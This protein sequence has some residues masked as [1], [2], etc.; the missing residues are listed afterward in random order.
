MPRA[1]APK[2]NATE[3]EGSDAKPPLPAGWTWVTLRDI[4]Q[5]SG[6]ITKGQKRRYGDKVRMVPYLRVANVQRGYFDLS[7]VKE[8]EATDEEIAALRLQPGDIL[9]NE[10]GD[11][12]KLGRGWVWNGELPECVHQNH[13]FR[14]R[15]LDPGISPKFISFYANSEGQRYFMEHATQTTNLASIN[16]TKLGALPIPLPP[17]IE[18]LRIVAELE[19]QFTRLDTGVATL[20]RMKKNLKRYR[21]AVLKAACEGRLVPIEADLARA[22]RRIFES[23]QD[24]LS[25]ILTERR[26]NPQGRG[27]YEE[28]IPSESVNLPPLPAGWQWATVEQLAAPEPY[29]ITDGPFGSNL[30]TEHYRMDGPRVI[31]L[32]NIGDGVY[33]DEEAHIAQEHYER[34]QKH[35]VF[36]NDVVIAAFGENPPRSCVIP[37]SLGPAI[38]KA[39]CI[40]FKPHCDILPKYVN[41]ALNS[42]PVRKRTKGLVHGV[43]RP[44]LNLGEIRL[45][46]LP[47]PPLAEQIRIVAEVD[48]LLSVA[49]EIETLIEVSLHRSI[50]LQ[51][52]L[53]KQ[54][55]GGALASSAERDEPVESLLRRILQTRSLDTKPITK[56]IKKP[57][58]SSYTMKAPPDFQSALADVMAGGPDEPSAWALFKAGRFDRDQVLSF[59]DSIS[60]SV[61][62]I[63]FFANPASQP[64]Q[65]RRRTPKTKPAKGPFRLH[66]LWVKQFKNLEEY[67]VS[68]EPEHALDVLLGWNGTG[69]S[70]LFEVLIAIFRDLYFW[71]SRNRWK[72]QEGLTGFRI[73]YE[74][75]GA[76]FDV[77]WDESAPRPEVQKATD[78]TREASSSAHFL[79]CK[80]E[81]LLLPSFVFWILF[82]PQ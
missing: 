5:I 31:R 47:I 29:S 49:A 21:A 17:A 18:Q 41:A 75:N 39:D 4:A 30:K 62:A 74:I 25:R 51:A 13:V 14:A 20:R 37:E 67:K 46:L 57:N 69:K 59:Y 66:M 32:Q 33:V 6:G 42:E 68:F 65:K 3:P 16:L 71:Q 8:I 63:K 34:L 55:F 73:R 72:P 78:Y 2:L 70:N 11:R 19:K 40:R 56:R 9:F 36:A 82:W 23:G 61:E 50:S 58:E 7:E 1:K 81:E 79:K 10:G 60:D 43:G 45:I 15:V 77:V 44:R 48:R 64:K 27:R 28:P 12:D 26:L 35:R 54:A 38:V 53:F 24:L 76:L 22:E 80:R 52:A